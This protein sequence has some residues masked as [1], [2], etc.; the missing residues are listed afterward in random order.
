MSGRKRDPASGR[1]KGE[2]TINALAKSRSPW[3]PLAE[4]YDF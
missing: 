3:D 2:D 1:R 4:N